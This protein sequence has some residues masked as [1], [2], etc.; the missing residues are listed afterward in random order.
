MSLRKFKPR[1]R[2][3]TNHARKGWY[4]AIVERLMETLSRSVELELQ[5]DRFRQWSQLH[6]MQ[7]WF[8]AG[9]IMYIPRLF[10]VSACQTV[11]VDHGSKSER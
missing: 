3:N 2:F 11:P 8:A 5:I 4:R 1:Q 7:Y 9:K 6:A 10:W